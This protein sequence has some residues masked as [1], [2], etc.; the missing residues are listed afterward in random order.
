MKSLSIASKVNQILDH[1]HIRRHM[2]KIA[3]VE[4][5][6]IM[7]TNSNKKFLLEPHLQLD[8]DTEQTSSV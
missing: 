4:E 8:V 5:R 6:Q 3:K 2:Q 1:K 7:A